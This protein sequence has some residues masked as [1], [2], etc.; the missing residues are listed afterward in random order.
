MADLKKS[1]FRNNKTVLRCFA[2]ISLLSLNLA[3]ASEE[4][5][6]N[7]SIVKIIA[8]HNHP[9]YASPWQLVGIHTV[10][11]SGVIIAGNRILTNAHVVADQTLLEVQREGSG[12]TY[13]ADVAFVCHSCDLA[14]LTVEDPA[15]FANAKPLEID[16]LPKLQSRV[17]VYGFPT[18]GETI[19]ITEGIVSRIE[20]D[21]YVHSSDRYLL[22]QV[23]AAINP[24]NSGGPAISGGKIIG[25]AMQALES[26]ENIG[27]IV[28]APIISHFL[29]DVKD[30]S[31]DGFPELDIYV[32]TIENRA[33]RNTLKLSSNVGGLLVTAVAENSNV[34]NLIQAGDV[35][36]EI[37]NHKIQRDGK[38]TLSDGLRVE[39][40]HLEYV[41]QV[42]DSLNLVI[43]R[44]G[45]QKTL[46]IELTSRKQRINQKQYD[47]KPSYFVFAGLLFQP[48]S[49]GYL[50][51]HH[52]TN[53]TLIP[54]IPSYTL[55][56][57]K[58]SVPDLVKTNRLQTVL[59]GRVLPDA[60]NLG[61]KNMEGMVIH[62]VND[63]PVKD[64]RHLTQLIENAV[65]D[66][67]K[68]ETDFGN[69]IMLD[70]A[71]ARSRNQQILQ[72]YQIYSDRSAE[73]K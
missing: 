13:N 49:Q 25:I 46:S 63:T 36:L 27:Y 24:G 54:Y 34:S 53:Y 28:P 47:V 39:S 38:V 69:V 18:G 73:L 11:G 41:K 59:L 12:V 16:G 64:L 3:W 35:L 6:I 44:N 26:A 1:V 68:I 32:Q 60:V 61:Y 10:T 21:Y 71:K 4:R 72:K 65:G 15:F 31:Y 8:T 52:R 51:A 9:D 7:S 42:G 56:G 20:V 30:G 22:V 40:S 67:L 45:Q 23:D 17:N 70:L 50:R 33:L 57:Y 2:I 37:D 58:K 5:G 29:E 43:Q 48:L 66:Y 62:A 55:E 14:I 19:S